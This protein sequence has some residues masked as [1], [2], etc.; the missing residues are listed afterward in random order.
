MAGWAGREAAPGDE[1]GPGGPRTPRARSG[2]AAGGPRGGRLRLHRAASESAGRKDGGEQGK[3][4]MG[5][6][7]EEQRW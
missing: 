3:E 6:R 7:R 2:S 1:R 4:E 5:R